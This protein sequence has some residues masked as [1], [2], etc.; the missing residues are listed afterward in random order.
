MKSQKDLHNKF[1]ITHTTDYASYI[2]N[3]KKDVKIHS[4]Y[5][6]TVNLTIDNKL[7]ALQSINTAISPISLVTNTHVF[8]INLNSNIYINNNCIYVDD[9]YFDY[10]S[11]NIIHSKLHKNTFCLSSDLIHQ[12]LNKADCL[13]FRPIFS[14][15]SGEN[16]Q[17]QFL[18]LNAAKIKINHCTG[19]LLKKNYEQATD[20]LV[21]LI[22]LGI[23]LTPSGDDFLCGVLAGCIFNDLIKYPFVKLLKNKIQNNLHK[24]ND[25]SSAFLSCALDYNF[26]DI[27]LNLPYMKSSNEIYDNFKKIGHSSGIDTLCGIYYCLNTISGILKKDA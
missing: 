15:K 25:I 23:G 13:G 1:F 19:Q 12:T 8:D 9:S 24:T 22:G 16:T 18:I 14:P 7:L 6:N 4:V 17:N 26:S 11:A 5:T 10:S 27:I 3:S 21:G 20:Q 2:L